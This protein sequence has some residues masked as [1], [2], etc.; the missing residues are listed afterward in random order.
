MT[1]RLYRV[2]IVMIVAAEDHQDA[3]ECLAAE[4][5]ALVYSNDTPLRSYWVEQADI[6]ETE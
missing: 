5:E 4:L 3:S 2:P 6:A 1:T